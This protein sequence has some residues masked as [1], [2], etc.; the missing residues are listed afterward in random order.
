MA[1]HGFSPPSR[2]RQSHNT[3]THHPSP[4][5]TRFSYPPRQGPSSYRPQ[6]LSSSRRDTLNPQHR[7]SPPVILLSAP[8][9]FT[10]Q[11]PHGIP[12][13]PPNRETNSFG[14]TRCDGG[15]HL[16]G[17]IQPATRL[18]TVHRRLKMASLF[19]FYLVHSH[20]TS[21]PILVQLS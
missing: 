5:S 7:Q 9:H 8:T 14:Q 3:S 19:F 6:R 4:S 2:S 21:P 17:P 13:P 11:H 1:S 12:A 18:I 16:N 15:F 20:T 10:H